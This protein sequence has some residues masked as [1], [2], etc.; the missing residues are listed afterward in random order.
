MRVKIYNTVKEFLSENEELLLEKEA[1]T[2][3]ILNNC[4]VN[5]D[6]EVKREFIFGRVEGN[7][8]N[9]KLIFLNATPFNLLVH[10]VDSNTL[11]AVE[12]LVNYLIDKNIGIR[13]INANK[14]ICNE[15]VDFYEGKTGDRFNEYLAMDIMEISKITREITLPKGKFREARF[16]DRDTLIDW[17][18]KFVKEALNE[19]IGYEEIED[20]LDERIKNKSIYVFEDDKNMLMSM[21]A[22]SRQLVNGV[23]INL[24]YSCKEARGKGY[25]IAVMY[26]LSKEYLQRGNKF[27]TLFVDKKNPISNSVY[28]KIGYKI[29]EDNYD[30]RI[31]K[32]N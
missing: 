13:G 19:N 30:Y 23:S 16:E 31:I 10:S 8:K 24:V 17:N 29:L 12:A 15:F 18:V 2:Q 22:V 20:K 7:N 25:G 32:N 11:E 3:L 26:N 6:K 4:F 14:K 27:C 5:K 1:V 28:K 21:A 9:I